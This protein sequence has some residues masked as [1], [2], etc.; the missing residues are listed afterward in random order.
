MHAIGS[1]QNFSIHCN[2]R[3]PRLGAIVAPLE[4]E[5]AD[6]EK[7][8]MVERAREICANL[9][10]REAFCNAG[11]PLYSGSRPSVEQQAR[12]FKTRAP[13]HAELR[14]ANPNLPAVVEGRIEARMIAGHYGAAFLARAS[15]NAMPL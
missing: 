1:R 10:P 2:A 3:R 4:G 14:H 8:T 7:S 9:N 15:S 11:S 13:E 5:A 12:P 6:G